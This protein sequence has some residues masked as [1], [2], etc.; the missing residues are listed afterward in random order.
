MNQCK[1]CKYFQRYTGEYDNNNYGRCQSKKMLYS[2]T[3]KDGVDYWDDEKRESRPLKDTDLLLYMDA[4]DYYA[5]IEVGQDFGCIH[6]EE[7]EK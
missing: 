3:T 7:A 1:N 5:N 2:E 4:E 6:Y